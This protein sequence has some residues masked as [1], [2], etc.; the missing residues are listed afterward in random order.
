M[1]VF[2]SFRRNCGQ[3]PEW[4]GSNDLL[5]QYQTWNYMTFLVITQ[6]E[7]NDLIFMLQTDLAIDQYTRVRALL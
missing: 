6:N 2:S 5:I 3:L 1:K 7:G 4:V